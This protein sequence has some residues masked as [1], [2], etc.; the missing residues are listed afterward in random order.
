[1]DFMTILERFGFPAAVAVFFMVFFMRSQKED[2]KDKDGMG[3]RITEIENYNRDRLEKIAIDSTTA[4]IENA[5]ASRK[6]AESS[7]KLANE[8][9]KRPC[10]K[11]H[12]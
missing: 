5:E 11:D 8:L 2:K 12:I 9:S 3:K 1:M 6:M 7:E 10:L 4:I